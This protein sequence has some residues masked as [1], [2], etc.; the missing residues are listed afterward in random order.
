MMVSGRVAG[1][2]RR[3]GPFSWLIRISTMF[4]FNSF[5]RASCHGISS[6]YT[7]DVQGRPGR[8]GST[9]RWDDRNLNVGR[10]GR[11]TVN[12]LPR[13][14]HPG[15][16]PHWFASIGIHVEAWEVAAGDIDTDAVPGREKVASR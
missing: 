12:G 3:A 4:R 7:T 9:G 11:V 6:T 15:V 5:T 10:M 13:G 16:P 2:V 14:L 8:V 1:L